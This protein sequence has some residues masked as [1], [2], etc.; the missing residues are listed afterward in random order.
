LAEA[1]AGYSRLAGRA[2]DR[3]RLTDLSLH[4]LL[5]VQG[6]QVSFTSPLVREFFAARYL[7][8]RLQ[9]DGPAGLLTSAAEFRSPPPPELVRTLADL[10]AYRLDRT[11]ATAGADG[12]V[13]LDGWAAG[14]KAAL[15][16]APGQA[17][18]VLAVLAERWVLPL[19][20]RLEGGRPPSAPGPAHVLTGLR[21]SRP[22]IE[23][24]L[25]D[26]EFKD[27]EFALVAFRN[28]T[29]RNVR[30]DGC[31]VEHCT[32]SGND[33]VAAPDLLGE[34]GRNEVDDA[35]RREY[36]ADAWRGRTP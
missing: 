10:L 20:S 17:P 36:A 27:C 31:R 32:F 12:P 18:A 26:L 9:K 30:L 23:L 11:P 29:F 1:V 22:W 19:C 16:A 35:S 8:D 13:G 28:N 24:I 34:P 6:G 4:C 15:A 21:F 33:Y 25:T 5:V 3:R 2:V 7:A 14:L